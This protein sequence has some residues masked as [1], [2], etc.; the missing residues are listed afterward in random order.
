MTSV[1]ILT[2]TQ[3]VSD[4][5]ARLMQETAV[6]IDLEMDALHSY[7]EKICLAQVSSSTE[8]VIIDPLAGADLAPL[9]PLFASSDIRKIFHAADYDL[10]SLK[11]DYGFEV[12]NLFDTMVSA[13]LC[14]EGK[15]GL[16]D[17]LQKYFGI[18]L[19]K[20]YQRA[21]WSQ[22][23]LKPEMIRYALK[24]PAICTVWLILSKDS[25]VIWVDWT[26]Y[27]KNARSWRRSPLPSM[28]VRFFSASKGPGEW[29][30]SN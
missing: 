23:P 2:T 5:T 15:I 30:V 13:Q 1:P 27:W 9:T 25:C 21:D 26:G 6:A 20:K 14:G 17:L 24:I 3:E 7:Q 18:E 22:R 12:R 10:R 11:R 19:D 8:T 16:A 28:A 29:N 4:L